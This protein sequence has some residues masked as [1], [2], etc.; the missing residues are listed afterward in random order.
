MNN[1]LRKIFIGKL[2]GFF[3]AIAGIILANI[4]IDE[5]IPLMLQIGIILWYVTFGA[6]IAM[7][8]IIVDNDLLLLTKIKF[9]Y[10][11]I[12]IGSW[13]NLVMTFIAYDQLKEFI[14]LFLG[15]NP[16]IS[17]PFW[18]VLEGAIVGLVIDYFVT[19]SLSNPR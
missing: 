11:S 13:L 8:G 14:A 12:L 5:Q 10:R 2:I 4:V 19:R 1:N 9:P 7:S 15:E 3:L 6:I 18:F 16:I 17:S